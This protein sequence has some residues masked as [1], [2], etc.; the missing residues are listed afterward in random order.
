MDPSTAVRTDTLPAIATVVV[1]GALAGGGYAWWGLTAAPSSCATFFNEHEAMAAIVASIALVL[2]GFIVESLGSFFEFDAIDKTSV[3]PDQLREEWW[4]FLRIAWTV[5]PI[6][7]RYLRRVLTSFKFELNTCVSA[8]LAMPSVALLVN[9]GQIEK[10]TG[11]SVLIGLLVTAVVFYCFCT[12][13]AELLANTR[14]SLIAGWWTPPTS[15]PSI[16]LIQFFP[17]PRSTIRALLKRPSFWIFIALI[18]LS[19]LG[20]IRI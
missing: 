11:W 7:H 4:Q 8:A 9:S 17:D 1:P 20:I 16:E 12:T 14:H 6:G 19:V 2:A 15:P 18:L 3:R 5:E 13:S 10:N